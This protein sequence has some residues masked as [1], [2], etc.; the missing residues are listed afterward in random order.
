MGLMSIFSAGRYRRTAA[1]LYQT[2]VGAARQPLF[3]R[4]LA[5][6]DT[7]EGRYE[8]IVLHMALALRRLRRITPEPRD[9]AQALVDYMA[10]D[11]DRSMRELGVGDLS[12]PRHMKRLGEGC[13]GRAT[14]YDQALDSTDAAG[15]DAALIRNVY[16]DCAPGAASLA[17]LQA[18]L[19][20]QEHHLASWPD[21]ELLAGRIGFAPARE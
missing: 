6:P 18:Y 16:S 5:V 19:R 8:M 20:E 12:V 14:A 11:L 17:A 9:L 2:V 13:F 7:I 4:T 3:Y 21:A 10:S 1:G 15:M